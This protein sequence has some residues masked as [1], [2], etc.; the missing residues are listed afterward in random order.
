MT[1][2]VAGD[3]ARVVSGR[4]ELRALVGR[5]G[6]GEVWR[7]VDRS[8]GRDVAVKV[9]L[10]DVDGD[11][12]FAE[13]AVLQR[14]AP[15]PSIPRVRAAF[16]EDGRV[17][18]VAD[19][20]DGQRASDVA[21]LPFDQALAVV[22]G[23]ADALDHLHRNDP[24][25]V[26]GDVKPSNVILTASD[27]VVLCDFGVA[28]EAGEPV[29]GGT[30]RYRAPETLVGTARTPAGDVYGL[31]ALAYTL[32]TGRPPDAY[33]RSPLTTVPDAQRERVER[34]LRRGLASD[35]GRRTPTAGALARD[36]AP[37]RTPHNL[38][39]PGG[40]IGRSAELDLLRTLLAT[41]RV[42]T[43]TGPGG[44]GKTRLA[45][46]A[47]SASLASFPGGVWL[48]DLGGVDDRSQVSVR[49]DDALRSGGASEDAPA[50]SDR[51]VL[52]VLDGCDCIAD[53]AAEVADAMVGK[54]GCTLLVTCRAPLL[55]DREAVVELAPLS[56]PARD[57][58]DH[59]AIRRCDAVALFLARA[60]IEDDRLS[61]DELAAVSDLC[62]RL[63]GLPHAIE[64]AA[65]SIGGEIAVHDVD[66]LVRDF[67]SGGAVGAALRATVESSYLLLDE[68]E[69]TVLRGVS[70][71]TGGWTEDAAVRV[72]DAAHPVSDAL[73]TL[74]RRSLVVVD[75]P[76]A[77]RFRMLESV[78]SY[79]AARRDDAGDT[80]ALGDRH[81][82][83]IVDL[84]AEAEHEL[85]GAAQ[86]EWFAR[87]RD[88]VDNIRSAL[89]WGL[90][91]SDDRVLDALET[92]ARL[93]V[94]WWEHG[95]PREGLGWI[96]RGLARLDALVLSG[97]RAASVRAM[98]NRA[99]GAL[100][101]GAA[102]DRYLVEAVRLFETTGNESGAIAAL[103]EL[104]VA[105]AV[106]GDVEAARALLEEGLARAQEL[107]NDVASLRLRSNL[108]TVLVIAGDVDA[109]VAVID[110]GVAAAHA[111]GDV[112]TLA[113]FLLNRGI[114]AA[115]RSE[116]GPDSYYV[117]ALRAGVKLDLAP[118]VME[119]SI[120]LGEH[121][122]M[123][124]DLA[125]AELL[126]DALLIAR[127]LDDARGVAASL[128]GLAA[129]AVARSPQRA[130]WLLGAADGIRVRRALPAALD[131]REPPGHPD[132]FAARHAI[133]VLTTA[134][135]AV[136]LDTALETGRAATEQKAVAEALDAE[137]LI[138]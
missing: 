92:A 112:G 81:L 11:A 111:A 58:V 85:Y 12:L 93:S 133:A 90:A 28:S 13:A 135:G 84:V 60:G 107:A 103:N 1:A 80:D 119:A 10:A 125:G 37:P 36:L 7:A 96:E 41:E 27:R 14:I 86:S 137:P 61:G 39:A 70:I 99:A 31:A 25:V 114:A 47:A 132:R 118:L 22:A 130:A 26:H 29:T 69:R 97:T 19:W 62:R 121:R 124:G 106:R 101:D 17:H 34:V 136:G 63:E 66:R 3:A 54:R 102:A 42:V 51:R 23:V 18:V 48:L 4:Y 24:P 5:G 40:L 55:L 105:A 87:L 117:D 138:S 108:A 71:F 129:A 2:W 16:S 49:V 9:Q 115:A 46:E 91:C 94:F 52:L 15:H 64:L 78:R 127:E 76:E 104:G 134:L 122:V 77:P 72:V 109:A 33:E 21:P 98:A 100:A 56:L 74:V 32:F 79:A 6:Q 89:A 8:T 88:D 44:V 43:V 128:E 59:L 116:E 68:F 75:R 126:E 53:A 113:T 110:E 120:L 131:D 45:C 50:S 35:P 57:E 95:Q 83:W 123:A 38:P 65:A 20:I 30:D 73:A 67:D 82:S